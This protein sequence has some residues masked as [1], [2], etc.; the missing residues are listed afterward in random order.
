MS[1]PTKTQRGHAHNTTVVA[2]NRR[3][4]SEPIPDHFLPEFEA[5]GLVVDD[6]DS[7]VIVYRDGRKVGA[8]WGPAVE[9]H[10][11]AYAGTTTAVRVA[12]RDMALRH[13]IDEINAADRQAAEAVTTDA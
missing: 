9:G 3:T 8:A 5:A 6:N 12:D 1:D 11:F 2:V 10:W 13:V 7:E 4:Y